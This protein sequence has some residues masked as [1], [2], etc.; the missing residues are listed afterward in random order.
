MFEARGRNAL[1]GSGIPMALGSSS[2]PARREVL[3]Y[4]DRGPLANR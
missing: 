2:R 4:S 3:H 1:F